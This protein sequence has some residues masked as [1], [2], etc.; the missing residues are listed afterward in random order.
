MMLRP[1]SDG[2]GTTLGYY[3]RNRD[4]VVMRKDQ[5]GNAEI[6][7]TH[8]VGHY[9]GL[10]HPHFGW[11]AQPWSME[12]HGCPAPVVSP[13]GQPTEKVDGSNCEEAGD[14]ICDTPPDYNGFG[15]RDCNYEGGACDPNGTPIDPDETNFMGYFLNCNR[16]DYHF[17]P[18]QQ[19]LIKA[20]VLTR[21][22]LIT[23]PPQNQGV[24]E[25][26]PT[27]ISPIDGEATGG[28]NNIRLRWQAVNNASNYL[29]EVSR[30][31][32]FP[33]SNTESFIANS[34]ELTLPSL[35]ADKIYYWKVRPFNE[36]STCVGFSP[37][38]ETFRTSMTTSTSDISFVENWMVTPNP[39]VGHHQ[40]QLQFTTSRSFSGLITLN[41]VSGQ[42]VKQMG[43]FQFSE[44]EN[45]LD[46]DASGLANGLYILNLQSNY[47]TFNE[48]VIIQ[49]N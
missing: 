16:G 31:P 32:N 42:L 49:K 34:T 18:M 23:V 8:E 19:E 33:S 5:V 9:F 11:D 22:N 2:I 25:D 48:K 35:E 30:L 24:V 20:D 40:F 10:P 14:R 44:G 21:Q 13:G 7:L 39:V 36:Y 47:G 43:Q 37:S 12:I 41:N 46:L 3:T 15:W 26:V 6:T 28:A 29:V 17:S 4:W 1:N 45:I 27:L 38:F